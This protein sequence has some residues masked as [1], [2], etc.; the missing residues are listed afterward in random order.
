MGIGSAQRVNQL[1]APA[2]GHVDVAEHGVEMARGCGFQRFAA[3]AHGGD[4]KSVEGQAG[5]EHEANRA[6]VVG[7][8]NIGL[9]RHNQFSGF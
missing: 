2:I 1:E 9:G 8:K 5:F 7:D 3:G 4:T 6:L